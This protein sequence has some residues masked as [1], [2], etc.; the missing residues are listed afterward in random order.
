FRFD[1]LMG[2]A[3]KVLIPLSLANVVCVMTVRQFGLN[4]WWLLPASLALFLIAGGI[5]IGTAP[6]KL[7][8]R[9][10]G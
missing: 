7:S 10:S 3:W 9:A 8:V 1:Q 2:L 5:S 6:A 4:A